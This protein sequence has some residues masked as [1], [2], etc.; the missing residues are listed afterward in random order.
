[1]GEIG[2]IDRHLYRAAEIEPGRGGDRREI[3]EDLV[4]LRPDVAA[5]EL[6][7]RGIERDL[8]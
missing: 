3:A 6:P 7:G 4:D 2:E 5:D 1:M 8:A